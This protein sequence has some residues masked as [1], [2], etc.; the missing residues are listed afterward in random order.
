MISWHGWGRTGETG[1]VLCGFSMETQN[2]LENSRAKLVEEE[3]GHDRG[4]QPAAPPE[5]AFG[6]D[7]NIVTVISE[8]RGRVELA[9][10]MSKDQVAAGAM[11]RPRSLPGSSD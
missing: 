5:P 8:R 6:T 1:Q 10:I 11:L 9:P 2:M 4:Q 7:T 3:R